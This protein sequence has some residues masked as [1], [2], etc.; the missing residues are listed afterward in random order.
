MDAFAPGQGSRVVGD[1]VDGSAKD[2]RVADDRSRERIIANPSPRDDRNHDPWPR[3]A[4]QDVD[5]KLHGRARRG[6]LAGCVQA[7]HLQIDLGAGGPD[8]LGQAA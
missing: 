2:A 1:A 4:H 7:H 6:R 8:G 3:A 5:L